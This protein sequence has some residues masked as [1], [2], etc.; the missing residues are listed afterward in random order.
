MENLL[1]KRL[2]VKAIKKI[3]GEETESYSFD[4]LLLVPGYAYFEKNEVNTTTFLTKAISL[5]IPIISAAMD[6]VTEEKAAITMA[7]EGGVGFIHRNDPIDIQAGRV[8]YVKRSTARVVTSMDTVNAGMPVAQ[9]M[10]LVNKKG[11]SSFPVVSSD[12]DKLLGIV[13]RR[14]IEWPAGIDGNIPVR[15]VM[16]PVFDLLTIDDADLSDDRCLKLMFEKRVEQ[17]LVVNK[18]CG[19]TGMITKKDIDKRRKYPKA[20]RD[21][22]GRLI[23]G[24]AIGVGKDGLERAMKLVESEVDTLCIDTSHGHTGNVINTVKLLKGE[25]GKDVQVIAGNVVTEAG[26][27]A[28]VKAGA[29]AI[30]IGIGPGSSCTTR[31]MSGAGVPQPTAI[32]NCYKY[33]QKKGIPMIADGG[34]RYAGD[35]TKSI[36]MGASSVMIGGQFAG[37]NE[38]PGEIFESGGEKF[39]IFRGMGSHSAMKKGSQ[40]RYYGKEVAEEDILAQGITGKVPYRGSLHFLIRQFVSGLKTGMGLCGCKDIKSLMQYHKFVKI[41]PQGR[42]ESNPHDII[43]TGDNYMMHGVKT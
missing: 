34:I 2:L 14:D 23:V 13:T 18:N 27:E 20:C 6:T 21:K 19:V 25:L 7:R 24:A 32:K 43:A 17:I 1:L 15:K 28:L 9:V 36:G 42:E 12:N 35:V 4:D 40:D 11:F 16:T 38:S 33:C 22:K 3:L 30:K 26:A 5:N 31:Q 37:T 10:E 41:S 29:D 39:K 8:D